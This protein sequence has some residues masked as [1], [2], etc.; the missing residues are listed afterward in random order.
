MYE[1]V[2]FCADV[3]ASR[4]SKAENC[5]PKCAATRER[6][7]RRDDPC[8]SWIRTGVIRA[9]ARFSVEFRGATTVKGIGGFLRETPRC[10][11]SSQV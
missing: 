4:V 6:Q 8:C 2:G 7:S 9:K 11:A 1:I 10:Y 5:C 3:E